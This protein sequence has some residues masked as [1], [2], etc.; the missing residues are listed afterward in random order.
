MILAAFQQVLRTVRIVRIISA[1][2]E[3][4]YN[5]GISLLPISRCRTISTPKAHLGQQFAYYRPA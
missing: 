4:K 1:Q 2:V 3:K 5:R